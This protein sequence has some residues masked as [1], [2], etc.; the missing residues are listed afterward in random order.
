[1]NILEREIAARE[2]KIAGK[3]SL[4]AEIAA[5]FAEVDKTQVEEAELDVGTS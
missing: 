2:A 1:M 3:D 5:K 4:Q